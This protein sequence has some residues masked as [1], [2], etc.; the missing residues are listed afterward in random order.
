MASV[1]LSPKAI[2][3]LAQFVQE[4]AGMMSRSL[5]LRHPSGYEVKPHE[6]SQLDLMLIPQN[7]MSA[8]EA[9]FRRKQKEIPSCL[10]VSLV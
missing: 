1:R 7:R 3:Q 2:A 5:I 6:E 9:R 10:C 4:C 8:G